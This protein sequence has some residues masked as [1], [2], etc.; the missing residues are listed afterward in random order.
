MMQDNNEDTEKYKS[1][2]IMVENRKECQQE[3][4]MAI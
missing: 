1:K 4:V 2:R 3:L